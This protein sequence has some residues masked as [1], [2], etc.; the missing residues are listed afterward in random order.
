MWVSAL[1]LVLMLQAPLPTVPAIPSPTPIPTSTPM[2]TLGAELPRSEIYNYLATAAA[3]IN[4]MP[5]DL[6]RP[7]GVS[8]LP[9]G[10]GVVQIFAYGK[11]LFSFSSAQELLGQSFSPV[12][13]HVTAAFAL[14]ILLASIF[15]LVKLATLIIKVVTWLIQQVIK[16][17]PGLG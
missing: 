2:P 17:I 9:S 7:G 6:S 15:L 5:D 16:L 10:D 1:L 14:I 12:A 8:V 4:A 13:I 3:N 11:W